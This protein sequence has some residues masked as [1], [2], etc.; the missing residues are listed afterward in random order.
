MFTLRHG[1]RCLVEGNFFHRP[2]QARLGRHPRDRRG[3][4]DHQQL[5]RR[6]RERRLLDHGG[7]SRFALEGYFRAKNC[8]IAFNTVIDTRGPIFDTNA[9][10]GTSRRT[11]RPENITIAN[12]LL[13]PAKDA[14][15]IKGT[16]GEGW[17]WQGNLAAPP[18]DSPGSAAPA[19]AANTT[20][21]HERRT[22]SSTLSSYR[23][24]TAC[25]GRGPVVRR[26]AARKET[27]PK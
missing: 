22:S 9:G 20:Q 25:G 18:A 11:L 5:H 16:E 7:H 8:L 15:L 14:Q 23:A 3:S 6:R 2:P 4:H 24:K 19:D 10:L 1:N 21:P 26:W 12:N 13:S 17:K 27:I